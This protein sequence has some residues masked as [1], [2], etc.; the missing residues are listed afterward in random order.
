MLLEVLSLSY[1][2]SG[3]PYE[4]LQVEKEWSSMAKVWGDQPVARSGL[5]MA[6]V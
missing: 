3:L 2:H 6:V 5:P 4:R 1:L